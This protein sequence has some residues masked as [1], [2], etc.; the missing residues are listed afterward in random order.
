ML[1]TNIPYCSDL[2][3]DA[4]TSKLILDLLD[5]IRSAVPVAG[6]P[7]P[8]RPVNEHV[9]LSL[10]RLRN[11]LV[12]ARQHSA[13]LEGIFNPD[14]LL[15]YTK[16]AADYQE[17]LTQLERI[18]DDIRNCRDLALKFAGGLAEMV[19]EHLR[20][21]GTLS[22]FHETEGPGDTI[23]IRNEGIKLKVV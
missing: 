1:E 2:H 17:I 3:I 7:E 21:T 5:S 15:R 14:E 20:I 19:V 4:G 22:G 16:Y 9:K 18:L 6:P 10:D 11:I 13:E 8:D 23:P 12:M